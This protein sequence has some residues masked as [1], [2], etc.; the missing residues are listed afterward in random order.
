MNMPKK[1]VIFG[2][3]RQAQRHKKA[4]AEIGGEILI[5]Y[6]PPKYGLDNRLEVADKLDIAD[7]AVI[8]SPN[9]LH[10]QQVKYA[11]SRNIDVIVEKPLR[12]P[13]EPL[14]DDDRVNIVLPLNYLTDLPS[15]ARRVDVVMVRDD[16]YY[17]TWQGDHR[18]TGGIFSHLFIHYIDLAIRLGADF[19]GKIWP[20]G[21]QER[22]VDKYDLMNINYDELYTKMYE[23]TVFKGGG[24]KPKDK[25]FLDWI[26]ERYCS[27]GSRHRYGTVRIGKE[28]W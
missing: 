28:K 9:Y 24:I 21:K 6:D 7:W 20:S 15:R 25:F 17:K 10:Y 4:I 22:L 19:S 13:W 5:I 11:L 1:F 8:A 26:M 16:E 18:K 23:E 14:I 2:D 3:G 27:P 12:M